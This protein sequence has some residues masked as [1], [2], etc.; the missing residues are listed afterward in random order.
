[1]TARDRGTTVSLI[2]APIN[3]N[4]GEMNMFSELAPKLAA[5]FEGI[6]PNLGSATI[7]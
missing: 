5:E 1:M 2:P 3:L 4:R 6:S 7:G